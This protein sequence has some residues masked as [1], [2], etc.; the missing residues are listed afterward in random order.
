MFSIEIYCLWYIQ[1]VLY[2]SYT[3]FYRKFICILS[4]LI[5]DETIIWLCSYLKKDMFY[6]W[7]L[8]FVLFL[9]HFLVNISADQCSNWQSC[10]NAPQHRSNAD[11]HT[12]IQL[13]F[14]AKYQRWNNIGSWTLN[15]CNSFDV[16]STLFCQR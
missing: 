5:I 7:K 9:S 11:E 1:H 12:L 16:V 14:S 10:F 4:N 13:S 8:N 6:S 15:W 2:N 3:L